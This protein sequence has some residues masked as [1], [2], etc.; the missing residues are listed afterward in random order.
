MVAPAVNEYEQQRLER[1]AYNK[2]KIAEL[3]LDKVS[4]RPCSLL[5]EDGQAGSLWARV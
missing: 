5:D 4:P 2:S 1:I 3:G